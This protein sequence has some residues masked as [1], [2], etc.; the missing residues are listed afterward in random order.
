MYCEHMDFL[1]IACVITQSSSLSLN[2]NV[3][4]LIHSLPFYLGYTL[5]GYRKQITI[6]DTACT[7]KISNRVG[8][9]QNVS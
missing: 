8:G 3:Q 6:Q 5:H 4:Y 7:I 1:P 2:H 9:I